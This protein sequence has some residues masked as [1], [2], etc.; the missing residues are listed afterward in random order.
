MEKLK[1]ETINT[2]IRDIR[3]PVFKLQGENEE[4]TDRILR[5][6]R[7]ILRLEK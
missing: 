7:N 1:E 2:T 6:I 4:I 3:N 5:D